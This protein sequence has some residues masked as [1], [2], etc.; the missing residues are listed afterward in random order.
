MGV[1][2][3]N[4]LNF[5]EHIQSKVNK[6]NKLMGLIRRTFVHL[7]KDNFALL[8]KSLVRPQLE[9]AHA[10]WNP[11]LK[12]HIHALENVQRRATKLVP[13][14]RQLPYA[15]RLKC[16]K[17]PTL[18]YRRARGDMIETYKLFNKY[19]ADTIPNLEVQSR[20]QTRGHSRK[21]FIPRTKT[22][23]YRNSFY[24]RIRK[25]WNSLHKEVV[26]AQS[27]HS[28][29]AAL[30]RCWKNEPIRYDYECP[31]PGSEP[32]ILKRKNLEL[33]IEA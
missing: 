5:E 26:T 12:K 24:I 23:R 33:N 7:D 18:A 8:Y 4:K 30:D 3:D 29:E 11:N 19:D 13:E 22:R 9:Y 28:F 25:T 21:M 6:A 31:V 10:V 20:D 1:I 32:A 15:Q 14:L 16:L 27:V 17:I 2:V